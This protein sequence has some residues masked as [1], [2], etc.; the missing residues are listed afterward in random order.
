MGAVVA[1]WLVV[2]VLKRKR[3][4][5]L[6]NGAT[7]HMLPI[8]RVAF[9]FSIPHRCPRFHPSRCRRRTSCTTIRHSR[10]GRPRF[11]SFLLVILALVVVVVV[12]VVVIVIVIVWDCFLD[13]LDGTTHAMLYVTTR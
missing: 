13:D 4:G 3:T 2:R 1:Q 9:Q 7:S 8:G 5:W 6:W 10:R 12:V 11:F